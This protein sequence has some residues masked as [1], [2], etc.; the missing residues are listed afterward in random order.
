MKILDAGWRALYFLAYRIMRVWWFI[1]RPRGRGAYV[2]VWRGDELLLI[3]NSYR[4]GYTVPC[5]N[6]KRGESARDAARREL[7]EEVGIRVSA[8]DLEFVCELEVPFENK[9]DHAFFFELRHDSGAEIHYQV[10]NREVVW[11]GFC[12]A[13]QLM[14]FP[15]VPHLVDYMKHDRS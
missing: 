6:I 10:D 2:A 3:Q 11:A 1:R 14:N 4:A 8:S 15:L 9:Q 13:K 12:A 7:A 5:G